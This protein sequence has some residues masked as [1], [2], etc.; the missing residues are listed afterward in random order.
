MLERAQNQANLHFSQ[1]AALRQDQVFFELSF[2]SRNG[3]THE[4]RAKEQLLVGIEQEEVV[5]RGRRLGGK[6]LAQF[7]LQKGLNELEHHQLLVLNQFPHLRVGL[8]FFELQTFLDVRFR[9]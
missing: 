8:L 7:F 4:L 1:V 9:T 3:S 2:H 6:Q 5:C